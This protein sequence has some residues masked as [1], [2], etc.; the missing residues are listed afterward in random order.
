MNEMDSLFEDFWNGPSLLQRLPRYDFGSRGFWTPQVDVT[1]RDGNLVVHADL[2]GL[3]SEDVKVTVD[4]GVLTISESGRTR[5]K[6]T[7]AGST[8][9]NAAT[10]PSIAP[11]GSRRTS[12]RRASRPPSRTAFWK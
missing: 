2:P 1:E 11:S 8:A 3:Q 9:R 10:A 12:T 7:R 5:T 4:E 6:T